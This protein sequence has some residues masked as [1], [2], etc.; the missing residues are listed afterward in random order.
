M[1]IKMYESESQI[2]SFFEDLNIF[3][4]EYTLKHISLEVLL[5]TIIRTTIYM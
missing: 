1:V 3:L 5:I 2:P 4:H